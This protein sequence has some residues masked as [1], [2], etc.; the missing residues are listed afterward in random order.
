[1]SDPSANTVSELAK[2]FGLQRRDN[3]DGVLAAQ[4]ALSNKNASDASRD[5]A[6]RMGA[7]QDAYWRCKYGDNYEPP[8]E[9]VS[10]NYINC[11][12]T[13]DA[14]VAE[15]SKI[16]RDC[17]CPEETPTQPLPPANGTRPKWWRVVLATLAAVIIGGLLVF[18][19]AQYFL[20]AG[21]DPA[22]YEIIATDEPFAAPEPF[23]GGN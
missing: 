13:S 8:G 9:D 20:D 19:V 23:T 6:R 12:V 2:L 4:A 21:D 5:H 22:I 15:L 16:A 18:I 11:S 14:A 10:V 7:V 17:P 1:M 3:A